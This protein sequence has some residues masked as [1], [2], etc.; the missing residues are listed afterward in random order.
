MQP[1]VPPGASNWVRFRPKPALSSPFSSIYSLFFASFLHN[2]PN[3]HFFNP[4]IPKHFRIFQLGSFG[5]NTL[6]YKE[7]PPNRRSFAG[8]ATPL[9]GV[10]APS[11]IS[12]LRCATPP[13]FVRR[14]SYFKQ[15][16][17]LYPHRPTSSS[18]FIN[19]RYAEFPDLLGAMPSPCSSGRPWPPSSKPRSM[20]RSAALT[21]V[22]R[23][24]PFP[25]SEVCPPQ[26]GLLAAGRGGRG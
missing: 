18:K 6:L 14:S 5:R 19:F 8:V 12:N 24:P 23:V 15:P 11:E 17:P 7:I 21:V 22:G 10:F 26:E 3:S 20:F 2:E 4:F 16:S 25:S 1:P 9:R 13:A